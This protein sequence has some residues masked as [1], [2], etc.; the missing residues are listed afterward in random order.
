[1]THSTHN[2][3]ALS[4]K[5]SFKKIVIF[6]IA[7]GL[8]FSAIYLTKTLISTPSDQPQTSESY[9]LTL[10]RYQ[11]RNYTREDTIYEFKYVPEGLLQ[12][13]SNGQTSTYAAV[14][15]ATYNSFD[16]KITIYSVTEK[17]LVIYITPPETDNNNNDD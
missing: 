3:Q 16:L 17:T 6:I 12:V 13:T 15:G 4:K 5:N 11:T 10:A 8:F 14:T 2:L 9:T 1:M 7:V